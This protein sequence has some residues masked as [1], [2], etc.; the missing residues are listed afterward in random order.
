MMTNGEME[1]VVT[2]ASFLDKIGYVLKEYDKEGVVYSDNERRIAIDFGSRGESSSI[3][4]YFVKEN[5]LFILGWILLV[6]E[7]IKLIP[8]QTK[9][10]LIATLRYFEKNY[11]QV[12]NLDFCRESDLMVKEYVKQNMPH[13]SLDAN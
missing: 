11:R 2:A 12:S 6:R 13:L 7:G 9:N 3:S 4:I 5:A 1:S 8:G 10:N